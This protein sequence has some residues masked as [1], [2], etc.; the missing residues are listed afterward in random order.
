MVCC[1]GLGHF[2]F[3]PFRSMQPILPLVKTTC[4]TST[5]QPPLSHPRFINELKNT[6]H[7]A[8]VS[9]RRDAVRIVSVRYTDRLQA[10]QPLT[11][12]L[13]TDAVK[14]ERHRGDEAMLFELILLHG[15]FMKRHAEA[16]ISAN[17]FSTHTL[18]SGNESTHLSQN[19]IHVF[20]K[21]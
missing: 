5:E 14:D 11:K 16:C 3:V 6:L 17:C 19:N 8:D 12:G 1:L 20:L 2:L 13:Y 4:T 15:D 10:Q 7:C 18:R 9:P 21:N